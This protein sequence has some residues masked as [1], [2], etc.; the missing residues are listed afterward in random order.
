M[1][2]EPLHSRGPDPGGRSSRRGVEGPARLVSVPRW[3]PACARGRDSPARHRC[4]RPPLAVPR[5]T[6]PTRSR[7]VRPAAT[8]RVWQRPA[9]RRRAG[10][11]RRRATRSRPRPAP[12]AGTTRRVAVS[13]SSP[14]CGRV[15]AGCGGRDPRPRRGR[16][17]SASLSLQRRARLD[18]RT[19]RCRGSLR[20]TS[21]SL[22][23][24][25][26]AGISPTD[27]AAAGRNDRARIVRNWNGSRPLKVS[28]VFDVADR[29][30]YCVGV[31]ATCASGP[32]K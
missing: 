16:V 14:E 6:S 22:L 23:A 31:F 2:P 12:A 19:G 4:G 32:G 3:S 28:V 1:S 27:V 7:P 30:V 20:S 26:A 11:N 5:A 9:L 15:P 17:W 8:G 10:P 21:C 29:A 24:A 18:A 13:A 25:S